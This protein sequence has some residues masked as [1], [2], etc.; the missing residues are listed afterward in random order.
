MIFETTAIMN[1]SA[2][3][4]L[5][6]SVFI[7]TFVLGLIVRGMLFLRLS[8][9]AEKT[10]TKMDDIIISSLKNPSVILLLML[11]VYLALAFSSLPGTV[12]AAI[13]K[14]LLILG[15]IFLTYVTMNFSSLLIKVYSNKLGSGVAMTSLAQN[16]VNISV[17]CVGTL[18]LMSTFGISITPILATL[19]VGGIAVALALQDT[20]SSLFA[21]IHI[22]SSGQIKLGDYIKL[23]SGEQGYV[24]DIG[25]RATKIKML[26]NNIVLVPN[27]KLTQAII[28][29]FYLPDKELAVLVDMGVH[30]ESDLQSV[31]KITCEV[32]G[33]VMKEVAGGVPDFVPFIRYHTFADFSINFTVI[34]RAKEFTDQYLIKHEFIKRLHKRYDLEGVVIPYPIRAINYSQEKAFEAGDRRLQ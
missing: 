14:T 27:S 5:P 8:R 24:A 29:N 33:Q 22:V 19:G 9:W 18:L 25:W 1:N 28:T 6:F 31:E 20:L 7:T 23:E 30:Y 26:P 10:S 15:I 3:S 16:V 17:F 21:G 12:I 34:L 13:N 4:V 32:A 2:G 11:A